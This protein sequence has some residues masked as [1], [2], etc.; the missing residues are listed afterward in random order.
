MPL[1]QLL[2]DAILNRFPTKINV[3]LPTKEQMIQAIVGHYKTLPKELVDP[4]LLDVNNSELK[5]ICDYIVK[6]KH[7]ASFR[8][9]N[10][11]L[12]KARLLS[13]AKD[14]TPGNPITIK[15]F[16]NAVKQH[17][18]NEN[19]ESNRTTL[20]NTVQKLSLKQR[21]MNWFKRNN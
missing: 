11:I 8:D 13:E 1:N 18:E 21:I 4:K 9:Y 5:R 6:D 10:Y 12:D 3:P 14:R 2:D 19:W 20:N 15:D 17:A 16:E 7:H